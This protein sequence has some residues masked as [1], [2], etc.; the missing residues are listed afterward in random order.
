MPVF[1]TMEVS[2]SL[3]ERIYNFGELVFDGAEAVC[4][5]LFRVQL[6]VQPL[7]NRAFSG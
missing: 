1:L 7:L 3:G 2:R 6:I 5:E 4:D